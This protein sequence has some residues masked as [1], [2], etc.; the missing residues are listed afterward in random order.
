MAESRAGTEVSAQG[1]CERSGQEALQRVVGPRWV[2]TALAVTRT[3][4]TT[5]RSPL[6]I[7]KDIHGQIHPV[8]ETRRW[9]K[10]DLYRLE[11]PAPPNLLAQGVTKPPRGDQQ[12]GGWLPALAAP[13]PSSCISSS[14][15][16]GCPPPS[17]PWLRAAGGLPQPLRT[18]Q[19]GHQHPHRGLR[20]PVGRTGAGVF[21]PLPTWQNCRGSPEVRQEGAAAAWPPRPQAQ[22]W[23]TGSLLRKTHG[24][25]LEEDYED[26]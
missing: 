7:S 3:N 15:F 26:E 21:I 2:G 13:A 11:P 12:A 5:S 4:N 22:P 8:P 25:A 19:H 24:A 23:H 16:P 9:S 14:R 1:G 10:D 20:H 17:S 18:R 6:A